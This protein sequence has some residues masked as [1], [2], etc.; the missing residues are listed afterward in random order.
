MR[1]RDRVCPSPALVSAP[2]TATV[3][4]IIPF[5]W[6][7]FSIL[8]YGRTGLNSPA[9]GVGSAPSVATLLLTELGMLGLGLPL[10]RLSFSPEISLRVNSEEQRG[11]RG[12]GTAPLPSMASMTPGGI[13]LHSFWR[14][15]LSLRWT[16]ARRGRV[17]PR[18]PPVPCVDSSEHQTHHRQTWGPRRPPTT[19]V[20]RLSHGDVFHTTQPRICERAIK[21]SGTVSLLCHKIHSLRK[22]SFLTGPGPSPPP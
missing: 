4:M 3:T 13:Y 14:R 20:A 6:S 16:L 15:W 10:W 11:N 19:A 12:H 5:L 9:G 17:P 21:L 22:E 1:V 8:G 7:Q 18:T 2:S